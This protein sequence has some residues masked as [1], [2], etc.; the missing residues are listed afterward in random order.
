MKVYVL[1]YCEFG[2][3][4][5]YIKAVYKKEAD[6]KEDQ[7]KIKGDVASTNIVRSDLK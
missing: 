7:D 6:A 2:D 5:S 1:M 4:Y 3:D